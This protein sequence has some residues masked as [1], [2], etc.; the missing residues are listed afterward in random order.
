MVPVLTTASHVT[1]SHAGKAT[2]VPAAPRVFVNGMPV[3]VQSDT[4]AVVGCPFTIPTSKP[5]PCVSIRWTV[6]ATRVFAG[7]RS[8]LVET[9]VGLGV[10]PEQVPQGPP[11]AAAIQQRVRAV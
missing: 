10:S 2:H 3:L 7:G 1:C 9:A 4:N 6:A 5:S 11:I 8:V